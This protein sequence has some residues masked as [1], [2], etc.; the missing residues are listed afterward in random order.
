MI[1][2]ISILLEN[3]LIKEITVDSLCISIEEYNNFEFIK[4]SYNF[5]NKTIYGFIENRQLYLHKFYKNKFYEFIDLI[6][7]FFR[8]EGFI[9]KIEYE[10]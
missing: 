4:L 2:Y 9:I 8:K 7:M 5:N 6:R 3:K 1:N 10:R